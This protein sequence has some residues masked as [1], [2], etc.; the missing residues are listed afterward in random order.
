MVNRFTPLEESLTNEDVKRQLRICEGEMGSNI[1]VQLYDATTTLIY[2]CKVPQEA[3]N[4][5]RIQELD[6]AYNVFRTY[7]EQGDKPRELIYD[8]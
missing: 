5:F 4:A 1:A 7:N 8:I 6:R 2:L 3:R